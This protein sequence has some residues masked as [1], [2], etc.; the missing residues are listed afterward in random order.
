M[1]EYV[2]EVVDYTNEEMYYPLG[3]FLD[4]EQAKKELLETPDGKAISEWCDDCENVCIYKRKIGFS[5][6]GKKVFEIYR[7]EVY[8]EDKDEYILETKTVNEME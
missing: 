7:E 5:G 4:Y 8:H 6:Q 2:Y 1:S 3:V